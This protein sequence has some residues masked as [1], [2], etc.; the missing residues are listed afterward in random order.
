MSWAPQSLEILYGVALKAVSGVS[1]E[2]FYVQSNCLER[3]DSAV[4]RMLQSVSCFRG[5]VFR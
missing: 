3:C 4:G 1:L 5:L 2:A